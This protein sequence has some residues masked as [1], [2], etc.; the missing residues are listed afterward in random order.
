MPACAPDCEPAATASSIASLSAISSAIETD[1]ASSPSDDT[2]TT[3]I[4]L[5]NEIWLN[6][7]VAAGPCAPVVSNST[8]SE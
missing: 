5:S 8:V 2:R 3:A 6:D 1:V 7:S 4:A